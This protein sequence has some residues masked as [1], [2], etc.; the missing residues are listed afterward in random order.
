MRQTNR[1]RPNRLSL[2]D[3]ITYFHFGGVF[4]RGKATG[5]IPLQAVRLS[6]AFQARRSKAR[7]GFVNTRYA[8][9]MF[10][11][12]LVMAM[13]FINKLIDSP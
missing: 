7:A 11:N 4:L 10:R 1:G 9:F 8:E 3:F 6:N 12:P 2:F 13:M 5:T